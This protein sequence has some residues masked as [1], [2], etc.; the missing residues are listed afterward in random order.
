MGFDENEL[1]DIE[2][3]CY[4]A[5]SPLFTGNTDTRKSLLDGRCG[6]SVS[7]K[8]VTLNSGQKQQFTTSPP[9]LTVT[10]K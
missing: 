4:C 9:S 2:I 5:Y 10:R 8:T 1:T 7:P 3:L 6:M